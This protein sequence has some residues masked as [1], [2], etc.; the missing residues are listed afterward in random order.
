MVVVK[1][2]II[3]ILLLLTSELYAQIAISEKYYTV[4]ECIKNADDYEVQGNYREA[5][6]FLNG[7]AFYIWESKDYDKAIE[8]FNRSITLNEKINN[9]GG[10]AGLNSNLGMIYNDKRDYTSSLTTFEKALN[11]RIQ[12]KE[13]MPILKTHINISV[14]LNNLLRF[15]ESIGHL[16]DALKL[17]RELNYIDEMKVC[18]AMLSE[19]YDKKGDRKK[20]LEFFDKYRI[21]DEGVQREREANIRESLN[22]VQQNLEL[23]E[24]EKNNKEVQ[25]A[26]LEKQLSDKQQQLSTTDSMNR[27]L[28]ERIQDA[29][30]KMQALEKEEALNELQRQKIESKLKQ[31]QQIRLFIIIVVIILLVFLLI[32]YNTLQRIK[33]LNKLLTERNDE[34]SIKRNS[35]EDENKI[36]TKLLSI[37]SHDLRTPLSAVY[38]F[39]QIFRSKT[40]SPAMVDIHLL[41]LEASLNSS[42]QMLDNMLY[43]AKNQVSGIKYNPEVIN[44]SDVVLANLK[45]MSTNVQN[46][47]ITLEN[48][49]NEVIYIYAD[50]EMLNII[51]RNTISNAIKFTPKDGLITI[52]YHKDGIYAVIDIQDNGIGISKEQQATLFTPK[53]VS[54]SGTSN[55]TGTGLGLVL[56]HDFVEISKGK[57]SVE[58]QEGEGTTF[59]ISLPFATM[60]QLK[61]KVK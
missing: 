24:S 30:L 7:A 56:V 25:L 52:S 60:G 33:R 15:D 46:K 54:Q 38:L 9:M 26:I 58:S 40:L 44:V 53:I 47:S 31:E 28:S 17:A 42:F 4:E 21:L 43:W 34:I 37:L 29:D 48:N 32:L 51:L 55:E 2:I 16:N 1:H 19:T 61:Q 22:K 39:L 18:Y 23:T 35:L 49:I 57:V 10:I 59:H 20:S 5:T 3:S 45:L 6:N 12:Q 27:T 8:L 11:I 13:K 36:R 50:K 41:R 14:V